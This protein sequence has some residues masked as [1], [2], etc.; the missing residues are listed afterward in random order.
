MGGSLSL[1]GSPPNIIASSTLEHA[2]YESFAIFEFTPIALPIF[3][4]GTIFYGLVG[5]KLLPDNKPQNNNTTFDEEYNLKM[6]LYG[7]CICL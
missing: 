1:L 7:K 2:G 4:V 3:I 6:Y 5:Y